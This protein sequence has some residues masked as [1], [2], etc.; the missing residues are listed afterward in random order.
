MNRR[1]EVR[2]IRVVRQVMHIKSHWIY[3]LSFLTVTEMAAVA[4]KWECESSFRFK[5][6]WYGMVCGQWWHFLDNFKAITICQFKIQ[7][8][9]LS[10]TTCETRYKN[11]LFNKPNATQTT[12]STCLP[13]YKYYP[14]IFSLKKISFQ[15][16][17]GASVALWI[18]NSY[19]RDWFLS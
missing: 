12:H 14:T 10:S 8:N 2:G 6:K 17:I 7:T 4:M 11:I 19:C 3:S 13:D 18:R 15:F 16:I 9:R 5:T 1:W